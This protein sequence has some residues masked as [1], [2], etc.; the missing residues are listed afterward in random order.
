MTTLEVTAYTGIGPGAS[1]INVTE[2][3]VMQSKA[4]G[5]YLRWEFTDAQGKT[6]SA[7]S[8]VEMTPGNKTGKWF[9][10]LTGKPTEVEQSRDLREVIGKPGTIM[11]ELNA[12][13][14]PKVLALTGR[15]SSVKSPV[16]PMHEGMEQDEPSTPPK[17]LLARIDAHA[18]ESD[19]LP[20]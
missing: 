4:G 16:K 14:Y 19:D 18:A 8:S 3:K 20:F 10:A 9:A 12:E 13:G 15:Q 1:D 17:S 11:V 7:N 5:D 6:A 2:C